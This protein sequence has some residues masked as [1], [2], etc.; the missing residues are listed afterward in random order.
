MLTYILLTV[1]TL[2]AA[3][4]LLWVLPPALAGALVKLFTKR[5]S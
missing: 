2:W 1:V 3:Y 5:R 4:V